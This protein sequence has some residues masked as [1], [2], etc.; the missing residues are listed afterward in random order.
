MPEYVRLIMAAVVLAVAT[1]LF[2]RHWERV[3]ESVEGSRKK[4]EERVTIG[5][6]LWAD[7]LTGYAETEKKPLW[8]V[9]IV[10][11]LW[12]V[13]TMAPLVWLFVELSIALK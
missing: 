3:K 13:S 5:M 7:Y 2:L 8:Q 10:E 9:L 4:D 6:F 11:T 1:T 12:L